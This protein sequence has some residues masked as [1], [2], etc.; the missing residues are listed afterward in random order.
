MHSPRSI[1][2][3]VCVLLA[4]SC[5]MSM[6][7][8]HPT[9]PLL[10][11]MGAITIKGR[12]HQGKDI[13]GV[14]LVGPYMLLVADEGNVLQI[15]RSVHDGYEVQSHFSLNEDGKEMDLEAIACDGK[16]VY[17]LG[18]H[19]CT[20]PKLND[21]LEVSDQHLLIQNIVPHAGRDV[22]LR[23]TLS[24]AGQVTGL[25]RTSLRPWLK[26]HPLLSA[27]SH[28]PGKENGI[29]LEGLAFHQGQLFI[30]CRGPILRDGWVPIIVGQFETLHEKADVR[31]VQLGGLGIR[32]MVKVRDG[33]LLIAGPL[34]AGPGGFHVYFWDG[35]DCLPG[36]RRDA[37]KPGRC[38][39]LGS[40]P[41]PLDGNPEGMVLLH[42][43]D[44]V[45]EL[46]VVFD[47]A[48]NG[49]PRRYR[50]SKRL[51]HVESS[52]AEVNR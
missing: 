35:M 40:F 1:T 4:S 33:F 41:E 45:Y 39:K 37:V 24:D 52:A 31:Y 11:D 12:V 26:K 43:T 3:L 2:R 36:Q 30:G 5:C 46:L 22:L 17:I 38:I 28:V 15:L 21:R 32:E 14:G 13:S 50:L 10:K 16:V 44:D 7:W 19:S 9:P 6:L 27:F 18:S 25:E 23:F 49:G 8:C 51:L 47:G 20:R 34:G 29:D 48:M 42:E